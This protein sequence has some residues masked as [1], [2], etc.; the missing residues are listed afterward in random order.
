MKKIF[1]LIACAFMF[2]AG[3]QAQTVT[4]NKADGSK[5]TYNASEISSIEFNAHVDTTVLHEFTGYLLVSNKFM[6][7]NQYYGDAAKMTVMQAGEQYLCKFEDATWGTGTFDITLSRG[8]ISGSGK[9]LMPNPHGGTASEYDATIS[10]SMTNIKIVAEVG[11]MGEVT[12]NWI[13]GDPGAYKVAG[14]YSAYDNI[15]V[16]GMGSFKYTSADSVSYVITAVND[17]TINVTVPQQQYNGTVMGDLTTGSY[18][19][20]NIAWDATEKAYV[21]SYKEDGLTFH[22]YAVK[23]GTVSYDQDYN[24]DKDACKIVVTPNED[25]TISI[26]NAYQMGSMPMVIYGSFTG[27]KK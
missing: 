9:L 10:G 16:G 17:T 25:G 1:T 14:T 23:D 6:G 13:Y 15:D 20:S 3:A 27:S 8:Q 4:I 24:L 12:I 18:T 2:V 19:I 11:K 22:F 26:S 21:R 5:V 7:E